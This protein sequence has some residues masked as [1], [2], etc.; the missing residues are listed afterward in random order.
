M[1]QFQHQIIFLLSFTNSFNSR[2]IIFWR[3]FKWKTKKNEKPSRYTWLN[4]N[5]KWFV[6]SFLLAMSFS[7]LRK[8]WKT[9]VGD[10]QW[11]KKLMSSR[12][13][14]LRS[15]QN[16][17]RVM[18]QLESNGCLILRKRLPKNKEVGLVHVKTKIQVVYIFTK[19]LK[20]ENIKRLRARLGV[21]KI[22][23]GFSN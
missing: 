18:K 5:Y 20:F 17:L 8:P 9:K 15:Y 4:W 3:E 7:P 6:L 11:R 13:M 1:K 21:Q 12:K 2:S 16:F 19:P 10:K 23:Y 14:T 22:N